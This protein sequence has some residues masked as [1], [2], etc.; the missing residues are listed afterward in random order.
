MN[1]ATRTRCKVSMKSLVVQSPSI[2]FRYTHVIY[3]SPCT[4]ARLPLS[5]LLAACPLIFFCCPYITRVVVYNHSPEV[6]YRVYSQRQIWQLV[7]GWNRSICE[8][9]SQAWESAYCSNVVDCRHIASNQCGEGVTLA[10]F[11]F[12]VTFICIFTSAH[13]HWYFCTSC[14]YDDCS[15]CFPLHLLQ[16]TTLAF[17]KAI[18]CKMSS[19]MLKSA[20]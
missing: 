7:S 19:V 2:P 15:V 10:I 17:V 20:V 13:Q 14:L 18:K 1:V 6:S 3:D 4:R 8:I 12:L 11:V 16:L 9:Y 5:G